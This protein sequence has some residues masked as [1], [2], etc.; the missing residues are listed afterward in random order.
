M[1]NLYK[2]LVKAQAEVPEPPKDGHNKFSNYDY[3]TAETMIRICKKT[4]GENGLALIPLGTEIGRIEDDSGMDKLYIFK[5]G[6]TLAHVS[7]ENVKM[8]QSYPIC[9]TKS[10]NWKPEDPRFAM[11]YD[12]STSAAATTTLAYFLR[13][14]LL[15]PRADE[16]VDSK[17]TSD[18]G[19]SSGNASAQVAAGTPARK[20]DSAYG[21][22]KFSGSCAICNETVPELEGKYDFQTKKTAHMKCLIE[23]LLE[24]KIVPPKVAERTAALLAGELTSDKA[25]EVITALESLEGA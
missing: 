20:F 4:L 16:E 18:T 12:K 14:L 1:E 17:P 22:N 19:S 6:Y 9:P 7:G 3:T 23:H 5:R 25:N 15:V 13:D 11:D 2:A 8:T 21:P 10:N 24:I